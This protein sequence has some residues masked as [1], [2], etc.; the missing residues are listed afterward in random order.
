MAEDVIDFMKHLEA[1]EPP[2]F[3]SPQWRYGP[4]EDALIFY[5]RNDESYAHRL[6]EHVTIFLSFD[7]DLLV[8]CQVKGVRR[9]LK[10]DGHFAVLLGP[11]SGKVELGLFFHLLAYDIPDARL[12]ELG[13]QAK[14]V[15]LDVSEL[16]PSP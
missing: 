9:R 4:K 2:A 15:E 7:G 12:I 5:F 10:T 14:G 16:L 13:Q 11:K 3:T 8:G 6:N 1:T